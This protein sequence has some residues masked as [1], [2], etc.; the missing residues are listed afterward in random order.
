MNTLPDNILDKI[1]KYKHQLEYKHV[2]LDL[3]KSFAYCAWCGTWMLTEKTCPD[4]W[5]E[6]E[7]E[8][9]LFKIHCSRCG[10]ATFMDFIPGFLP[11]CNDC[12]NDINSNNDD[13]PVFEELTVPRRHHERNNN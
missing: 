9:K 3:R 8:V 1:Y 6:N 5:D 11:M 13:Y 12:D 7:E 2:M 10:D 4:C